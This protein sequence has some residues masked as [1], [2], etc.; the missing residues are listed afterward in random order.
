MHTNLITIA[1]DRPLTEAKQS[2]EEHRI[3]HLL[4]ADNSGELVGILSDR[5][6]ARVENLESHPKFLVR[7]FM[8][9]PIQTFE[10]STDL[11][12]VVQRMLDE[13]ISAILITRGGEHV[14]IIT[15]H[16]LLEMLCSQLGS[17]KRDAELTLKS[18]V[19]SPLFR[20]LTKLASDTGI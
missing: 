16:D 18:I 9:W 5:D 10:E 2:M 17:E 11:Q 12:K 3:R 13:K 20:N 7:D 19:L 1:W 6:V 4:V 14:G 15:S 8:S